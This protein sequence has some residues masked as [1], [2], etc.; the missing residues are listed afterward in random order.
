MRI[1]KY[2][3]TVILLCISL[4]SVAQSNE[5]GVS[6]KEFRE[7]QKSIALQDSLV[8]QQIDSLLSANDALRSLLKEKTDTISASIDNVNNRIDEKRLEESL[9]SAES[10]LNKQNYLLVGFDTYYTYLTILIGLLTLGLPIL[11]W[12]FGIRP[13]RKAL[14]KAKRKFSE[15]LK[16][17]RIEQ[18]NESIENLKSGN[19]ELITS[20]V[21]FVLSLIPSYKFRED[22]LYKMYMIVKY[23][24]VDALTKDN[25]S[26]ILSRHTY[27]FCYDYFEYVKN[28]SQKE[29][30][31]VDGKNNLKYYTYLYFIGHLEDKSIITEKLRSL[32]LSIE[33]K[34]TAFKTILGWLIPDHSDVFWKLLNHE[35]LI[36]EFSLQECLEL[37]NEFSKRDEIDED[38]YKKLNQ[39]KLVKRIFKLQNEEKID[40]QNESI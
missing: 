6:K 3:I 2:T 20:S 16:E 23:A 33:S 12:I 15:H 13:A 39:T 30:L 21:N 29:L 28:F 8:H 1:G 35:S 26:Y 36:N 34:T 18:I 24:N 17:Y 10:T 40:E 11:F 4:C 32:C 14:K 31:G 5:L 7:F 27:P 38:I 37:K 25:L 9:K 22:Q 19:Q